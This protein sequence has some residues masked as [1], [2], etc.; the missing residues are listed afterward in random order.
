[1]LEN[2]RETS[3]YAVIYA[4]VGWC[5]WAVAVRAWDKAENHFTIWQVDDRVVLKRV[6]ENGRET[7]KIVKE[8]TPQQH[9]REMGKMMDAG[10]DHIARP[11]QPTF[12]DIMRKAQNKGDF[13]PYMRSKCRFA[14]LNL[15]DLLRTKPETEWLYVRNGLDNFKMEI[16]LKHDCNCELVKVSYIGTEVGFLPH[17]TLY[18]PI[19]DSSNPISVWRKEAQLTDTERFM[20]FVY[21]GDIW[22]QNRGQDGKIDSEIADAIAK[23]TQVRANIPDHCQ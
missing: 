9:G 22:S 23:L 21:L 6:L 5:L 11:A 12:H 7:V 2:G 8:K 1:V 18:G 13:L 17:I 16:S 4:V 10:I 14:I 15:L 20:F 19:L 3:D